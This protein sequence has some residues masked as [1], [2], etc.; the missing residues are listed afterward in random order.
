MIFSERLLAPTY[1]ERTTIP[2]TMSRPDLSKKFAGLGAAGLRT[3][4]VESFDLAAVPQAQLGAFYTGDA[5]RAMPLHWR[6]PRPA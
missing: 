3:W 5:G 1:K 2:A 6:A 4:R